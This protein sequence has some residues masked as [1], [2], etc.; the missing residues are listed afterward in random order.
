MQLSAEL[1]KLVDTILREHERQHSQAMRE[2]IAAYVK[3]EKLNGAHFACRRP[4]AIAN[5]TSGS[6]T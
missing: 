6:R 1:Q 3:Q 4:W 2:Q 5:Q